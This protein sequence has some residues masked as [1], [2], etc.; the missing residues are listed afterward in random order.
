[1]SC[2]LT[3]GDFLTELQASW[4][5]T[6]SDQDGAAG[7]PLILCRRVDGGFEG[8]TVMTNKMANKLF[9][10]DEKDMVKTILRRLRIP[11]N[12]FDNKLS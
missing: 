4:D 3:Y 10:D 11:E 6:L 5:V 8:C 2:T 9:V 1:M 7:D 12:I